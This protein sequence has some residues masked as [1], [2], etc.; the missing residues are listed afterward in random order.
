MSEK[1]NVRLT[2][3][4]VKIL[5]KFTKMESE[6]SVNYVVGLA[7]EENISKDQLQTVIVKVIK[8]LED[9]YGQP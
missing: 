6:K 9:M 3:D 4:Q 5:T 7:L 1:W 8:A 2:P